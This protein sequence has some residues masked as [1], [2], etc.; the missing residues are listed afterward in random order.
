MA[1]AWKQDLPPKGGYPEITYARNLPKRGPSGLMIMLG[2]VAVMALGFVGVG[3]TNRQ[4]RYSVI[5]K[6]CS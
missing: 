1:T 2:G 4:R 6:L 3:I 5:F